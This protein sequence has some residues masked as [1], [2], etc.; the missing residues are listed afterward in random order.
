MVSTTSKLRQLPSS[1]NI[2]VENEISE[3]SPTL[4]DHHIG[5]PGFLKRQKSEN[6]SGEKLSSSRYVT[7]HELKINPPIPK[8][9]SLSIH[10][11]DR[12]LDK[13]VDYVDSMHK[14]NTFVGYSA[15][16][17]AANLVSRVEK[18]DM[19]ILKTFKIFKM[20]SLSISQYFF[21][22]LIQCKQQYE[23]P[24]MQTQYIITNIIDLSAFSVWTLTSSVV[25]PSMN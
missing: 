9:Q 11:D 12:T 13:V 14:K 8:I 15:F 6:S 18:E 2:A 19:D 7:Y 5:K 1:N 4:Q 10:E 17:S 21:T 23:I 3:Q 22:L 25:F 16:V 20:D 24:E